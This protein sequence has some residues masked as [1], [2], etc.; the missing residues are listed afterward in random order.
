MGL[1]SAV[2]AGGDEP[3]VTTIEHLADVTDSSA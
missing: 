3:V 2:C 1:D